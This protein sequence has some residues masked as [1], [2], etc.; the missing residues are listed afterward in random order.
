MATLKKYAL[1]ALPVIVVIVV[2][3]LVKS[4]VP[5]VGQYLP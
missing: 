4:K 3:N 5:V 2:Y 1:I